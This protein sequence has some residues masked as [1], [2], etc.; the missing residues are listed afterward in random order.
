V[1]GGE[2]NAASGVGSSVGGG[3]QNV[4]GGQNATVPGGIL[5]SA[6][7]ANSFAAGSGATAFFDGSFVWSDGHGLA[8]DTGSSQFVA[9]AI[10]GFFFYTSA[11]LNGGATLPAGSGSWSSLSDRDAK[12]NFSPV[13]SSSVL[14][15][16]AAMP[17]STWNYRSQADS[18]HHLGPTAQD[19][20]AAF[21][22]GEDD[23]HISTVD[24]EGVA[25]ASIQALYRTVT[26]L[27]RE[28]D[29][30]NGEVEEL[31]ARLGRLEQSV[32]SH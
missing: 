30:K 23:K 9:E 3:F 13:D 8:Q 20:Q 15:K 32:G 28:V 1:D 2:N 10:G 11:G 21:G 5:N 7:G 18:I 27:K 24:S 29:E 4:A 19:F 31:R 16:L 14:E 17:I 12:T 22:L 26:E 6:K 25:L